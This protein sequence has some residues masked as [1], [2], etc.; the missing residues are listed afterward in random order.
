MYNYNSVVI[1][2]VLHIMF[3]MICFD[4]HIQICDD[5]HLF[6]QMQVT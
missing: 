4:I 5:Y 1:W 2:L 6:L 3:W